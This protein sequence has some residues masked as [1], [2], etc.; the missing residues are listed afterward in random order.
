MLQVCPLILLPFV[1][2]YLSMLQGIVVQRTG[3]FAAISVLFGIFLL[4]FGGVVILLRYLLSY[5]LCV[6]RSEQRHIQDMVGAMTAGHFKTE[7]PLLNNFPPVVILLR[8]LLRATDKRC[9]AGDRP[10]S[11]NDLVAPAGIGAGVSKEADV[12]AVDGTGVVVGQ[13]SS[14]RPRAGGSASV[15]KV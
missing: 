4:I 12:A 1:T 13:P 11:D 6:D 5:S 2:P 3:S 10:C 8:Y 14:A 9:T 15:N 7:S